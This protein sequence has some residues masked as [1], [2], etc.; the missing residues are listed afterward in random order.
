MRILPTLTRR[1]AI[2]LAIICLVVGI[3]TA[4][5]GVPQK[6]LLRMFDRH[7]FTGGCCFSWNE[8]V[9]VTE[10][11]KLV[12]V[13]VTWSADFQLPFQ[14]QVAVGL[15]VNGS[16][17]QNLGG[18]R[19]EQSLVVSE[20]FD[21]RTFQFVIHP[22]EGLRSGENTFTLCGGG[23]S[24]GESITIGSNTLQARLSK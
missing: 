4:A 20:Q 18:G 16:V 1:K 15:S 23:L 7:T 19:F 5:Y 6:Q 21:T 2:C 11:A 24:G 17:C 9:S 14:Q 8:S 13:V 22:S 10:P 3:A 12:P